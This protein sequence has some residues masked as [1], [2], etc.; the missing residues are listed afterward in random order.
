[1][2]DLLQRKAISIQT[3]KPEDDDELLSLFQEFYPTLGWTKSIFKWLYYDNPAGEAHRWI[4]RSQGKLIASYAAVP[5]EV[6]IQGKKGMGWRMQ[7]L[8]TRTGFGGLGIF[9]TVARLSRDYLNQ[10]PEGFSF[11]FPN[12][13][14]YRGFIHTG[15]KSLFRIPLWILEPL[16]SL[17]TQKPSAEITPIS[18]FDSQTDKIW[19]EA[20]KEVGFAIDRN[21]ACLNWR[22][23]RNPKSK[24][25]PFLIRGKN[26]E[27]VL[28][29]KTYDKEDGSRWAHICD[30]FQAGS[31]PI[32]TDS[33]VAFALQSAL[34]KK[35]QAISTWSIPQSRFS[36]ALSK[37]GFKLQEQINRWFVAFPQGSLAEDS[38]TGEN[39]WHLGMGDSDVY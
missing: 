8:L 9:H 33:G 34:E 25:H 3:A 24:Y 20:K 5:Y 31:D 7:D 21:N 28:I 39:R 1:M 29:L 36:S 32:L 27:G 14:S 11:A 16:D 19:N 10:A 6:W 38:V 13:K 15:W 35:C 26:D 18:S 37:K 4:A 30:Y 17:K 23:F 12:E 22:Y 2:K